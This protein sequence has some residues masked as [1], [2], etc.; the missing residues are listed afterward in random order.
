MACAF[1]RPVFASRPGS[2]QGGWWQELVGRHSAI[3][4]KLLGYGFA[5]ACP[6]RLCDPRAP[7]ASGEL[8]AA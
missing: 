4:H 6:F 5:S 2:V 8:G 1:S 7:A 3:L